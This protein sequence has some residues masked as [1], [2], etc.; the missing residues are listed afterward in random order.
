[1]LG[2]V[3]DTGWRLLLYK[4]TTPSPYRNNFF[5]SWGLEFVSKASSCIFAVRKCV[6][7]LY[8]QTLTNLS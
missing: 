3:L 8:K 4:L 7:F 6:Q 5:T 1:M 2:L